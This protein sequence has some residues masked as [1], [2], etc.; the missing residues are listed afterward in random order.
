M[1]KQCPLGIKHGGHSLQ[2]TEADLLLSLLMDANAEK[3]F[4]GHRDAQESGEL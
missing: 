4:T 3:Q 1:G 2:K